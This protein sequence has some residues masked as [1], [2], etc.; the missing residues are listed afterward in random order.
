MIILVLCVITVKTTVVAG[1]NVSF[2]Y[3]YMLWLYNVLY[4][5]TECVCGGAKA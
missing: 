2:L 3:F 4:Y 1:V 5:C